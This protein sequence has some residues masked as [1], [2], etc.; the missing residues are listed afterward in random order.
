MCY[1]EAM[2]RWILSIGSL[3]IGM[4]ILLGCLVFGV[5]FAKD[6]QQGT[7]VTWTFMVGIPVLAGVGAI[8]LAFWGFFQLPDLDQVNEATPDLNVAP[9]GIPDESSYWD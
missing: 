9:L 3:I 5:A 7:W 2:A 6:L 1:D 8:G 4:V